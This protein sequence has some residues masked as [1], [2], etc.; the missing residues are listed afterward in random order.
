MMTLHQMKSCVNKRE[1][2][3]KT[4]TK[5]I[6]IKTFFAVEYLLLTLQWDFYK[7]FQISFSYHE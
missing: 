6:V 3:P 1:K 5:Q 7:S 4:L 2:K